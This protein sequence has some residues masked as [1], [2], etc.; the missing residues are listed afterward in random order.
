MRQITNPR[1]SVRPP[2][3][4]EVDWSSQAW[5]QHPLA[6]GLFFWHEPLAASSHLMAPELVRGVPSALNNYGTPNP[7]VL[8]TD[9]L[10]GRYHDYMAQSYVS[11][12]E[13]ASAANYSFTS[14]S[15]RIVMRPYRDSSHSGDPSTI[16]LSINGF[17]G[18]HYNYDHASVPSYRNTI[19]WGG[20]YI[21]LPTFYANNWYDVLLSYS[22]NS[23]VATAYVNGVYSVSGSMPVP[24]GTPS[25]IRVGGYQGDPGPY[26]YWEGDISRV[27][28]WDRALS[29]AEVWGLY[30]PQT[31]WQLM[32]ARPT[33]RWFIPSSTPSTL[34]FRRKPG[35][36]RI[37]LRSVA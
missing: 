14:H 33:R 15:M 25:K 12:A 34:L 28:W 10:W 17:N 16:P 22:A 31:R 32:P 1:W 13:Y 5:R 18:W 36:S 35:V 30:A 6:R 19:R 20:S 2:S 37:G 23:G 21:Q 3:P 7:P 9:P 29:A 26:W 27:M 4:G 24:S 11:G 8:K